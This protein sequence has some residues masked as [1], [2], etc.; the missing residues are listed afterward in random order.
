MDVR[1]GA[2]VT[3]ILAAAEESARSGRSVSPAEVR[4]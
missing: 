4:G 2:R 1:F 3:A